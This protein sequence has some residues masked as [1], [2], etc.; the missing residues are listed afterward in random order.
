M[1]EGMVGGGRLLGVWEEEGGVGVE[2]KEAIEAFVKGVEVGGGGMIE[3][4]SGGGFGRLEERAVVGAATGGDGWE[5]EAVVVGDDVA[6]CPAAA[7][8]GWG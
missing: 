2:G 4:V 6:V 7:P 1:G 8:A 5:G 3:W